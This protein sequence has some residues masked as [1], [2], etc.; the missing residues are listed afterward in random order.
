[1]PTLERKPL[2]QLLIARGILSTDHLD[3]ALEEQKRNNFQKLLGEILVEQRLCDDEQIVEALADSYALPFARVSP[4]LADPKAAAVL[5]KEFLDK[6]CILPLFLV[7][8]TLTVAVDEPANL[9]L[10]EEIQR[11]TGYA[12]Q[13]VAATRRDIQGTLRAYHPAQNVFVIDDVAGELQLGDLK[14]LDAR[15]EPTVLADSAAADAPAVKL[16]D[17]CIYHAMKDAASDIH[18]E[19]G[20]NVLRVRYRVDGRLTEK[21]RPPFQLHAAIAARVKRMAGLNPAERRLPQEGAVRLLVDNKPIELRASTMPGR[22]GE[23]IVLRVVD[24]GKAN[25]RLERLGFDYDA[26]KQWRKLLA[27]RGGVLLV[28]GPTGCGKT[29]TLYASLREINAADLNICTIEDPVESPIPGVNQFQINEPAGFS[30]AAALRSLLRQEPDAVMIQELR[31]PETARLATQAALTG[32]LVLSTLHTPD[33][34]AAVTRLT[35]LGVEPYLVAASLAGVLGQRLVRKL[36]QSC[37]EPYVPT[38]AERRQLE[39]LG[40]P[41]IET[42][43]RPKGC[44][45][46]HNRGFSGRVGIFE[47]LIADDSL[48]DRISHGIPLADLRQF[49]LTQSYKPLRTDGIEKARAGVTTLEEVFRATA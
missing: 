29:S 5:T 48:S 3:R 45:R 17:Y 15:P 12:V 23:K 24:T 19:P 14:L 1:M 47:L 33:A 10:V 22:F 40:V 7:E 27:T 6:H 26:L 30:F 28:T 25:L 36:C 13:L 43:H 20:D 16:V 8:G 46:C 9:F 35:N 42:L 31:D 34:P 38:H 18:F 44:P 37:K 11:I 49:A 2:G 21:L 4:R 39:K 41:N 32:H